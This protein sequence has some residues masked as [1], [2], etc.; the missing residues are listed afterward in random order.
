[1]EVQLATSQFGLSSPK[2]HGRIRVRTLDLQIGS[3]SLMLREWG[4]KT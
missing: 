3:L 2:V 4:I 1:M